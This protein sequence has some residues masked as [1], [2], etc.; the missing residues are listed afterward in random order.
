MTKFEKMVILKD[1][2]QHVFSYQ[3]T[4]HNLGK[5]IVQL[6]SRKW[7]IKDAHSDIKKVEGPG[8]IGKQP[9]IKPG[10]QFSYSSWCPL[11]TE[12]GKMY[13]HFNMKR[14]DNDEMFEATVPHFQFHSDFVLN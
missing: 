10:E 1:K 11:S 3:I 6:I 8:V 4:V 14:L 7:I 9:V 2:K 5:D 13:G 12:I